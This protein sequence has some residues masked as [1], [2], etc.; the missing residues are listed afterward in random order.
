MRCNRVLPG[1]HKIY[2]M[3]ARRVVI[4][5]RQEGI[6]LLSRKEGYPWTRTPLFAIIGYYLCGNMRHNDAMH[7]SMGTGTRYIKNGMRLE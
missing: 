5:C 6:A 3:G 4:C 2:K 1:R 7:D